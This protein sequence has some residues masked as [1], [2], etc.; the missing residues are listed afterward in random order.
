MPNDPAHKD[1]ERLVGKDRAAES[2]PVNS[3]LEAGA[4]VTL[5]SDWDVSNLNP[6]IGMANSLNRAGE[7]ITLQVRSWH[8]SNLIDTD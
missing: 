1:L 4:K 6:F 5:S 8:Y 7:S 3:L 2:V